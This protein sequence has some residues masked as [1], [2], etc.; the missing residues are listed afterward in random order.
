[1]DSPPQIRRF[2]TS[3]GAEIYRLPL[4]AFPNFWT[5][6]Y[7]VFAGDMRVLIDSGSGFGNSNDYLI[8][9]LEGV[10]KLRSRPFSLADLTHIFITHGHID[11]FGGLN[12]IRPQTNAQL[13]IHELDRRNLTRHEERVAVAAHHLN[14]FLFEAGV[15]DT[16]RGN[17]LT[18]YRFTKELFRS[19]PVDF[20][21]EDS[22]M[23]VGPF[24]FFH[25]PGHSA[26]HVVIR[27]EEVLFSGDHVLGEISPHQAPERLTLSTGLEHYLSSLDILEKWASTV[28]LTLGGHKD[29]V[30]DLPKRLQEIRD[31]HADRL[32]QVKEFMRLPH[33]I[34]D[35][36]RHLF[37]EVHG[38]NI[39]LALEEAGAHVEYLYQRGWLSIVNLEEFEKANGPVVLKYCC[40]R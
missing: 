14:R 18:M 8:S 31:V 1:M 22:G 39:L 20:T 5:Y 7:L 6:A 33:T 29:P 37:R 23:R 21:F 28:Q 13:G 30:M 40:R 38:Y 36:S 17:L 12:F 24:E 34:D 11:H 25:V 27:L 16:N 9:G 4:E 19:V 3:S 32:V 15:S 10:G 35:L 2:E 26:G